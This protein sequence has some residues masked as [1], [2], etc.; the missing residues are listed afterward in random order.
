M[1]SD[2]I[3]GFYIA[4]KFTEK[5]YLIHRLTK[6]KESGDILRWLITQEVCKKSHHTS[7]GQHFHFL[8]EFNHDNKKKHIIIYNKFMRGIIDTYKLQGQA[9][10]GIGKQYGKI[11]DE[12]KTYLGY[13]SYIVKDG[14]WEGDDLTYW[15]DIIE[16][17]IT[18][19][20]KC[21]EDAG[22]AWFKE[23]MKLIEKEALLAIVENEHGHEII[24]V[25]TDKI[26]ICKIII[27]IYK[28]KQLKPPTK[29]QMDAFIKYYQLHHTNNNLD[30]FISDW[31]YINRDS[32]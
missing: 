10:N 2:R 28:S 30:S 23:L 3:I 1:S 6:F 14:I 27:T 15:G 19:W 11:K 21:D 24:P 26:G 29:A 7:D 17:Q 16:N 8:V 31:Y 4:V 18:K 20:E 25:T 5:D 9:K 32:Y 13:V 12:V 22:K